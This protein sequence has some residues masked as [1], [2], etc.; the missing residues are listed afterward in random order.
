MLGFFKIVRTTEQFL[1]LGKVTGKSFRRSGAGSVAPLPVRDADAFLHSMYALVRTAREITIYRMSETQGLEA[2]YGKDHPSYYRGLVQKRTPSKM[3]G[4][5]WTPTRPGLLIDNVGVATD[6]RTDT[7]QSNAVKREWG[8]F[9][10]CVQARLPIDTS[11]HVGRVAP[12]TE[13]RAFQ[14]DNGRTIRYSGGGMQF[15]LP[16]PSVVVPENFYEVK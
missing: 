1:G 5:W 11:I 14:T 15:L 2:P 6:L 16:S 9:D 13:N 10:L 4:R 12:Q 8:R 7:R 3:W